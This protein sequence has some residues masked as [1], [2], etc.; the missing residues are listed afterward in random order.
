MRLLGVIIIIHF[1][2]AADTV[3]MELPISE[4]PR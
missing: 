2:Q 1:V 3:L 4:S